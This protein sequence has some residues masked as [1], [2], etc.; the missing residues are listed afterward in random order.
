MTT[1][2]SQRYPPRIRKEGETYRIACGD[3]VLAYSGDLFA[4]GFP[5]VIRSVIGL[6]ERAQNDE[7]RQA[8]VRIAQELHS[9]LGRSLGEDIPYLADVTI[10]TI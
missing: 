8:L 9:E 5:D 1:N 6:A 2:A 10:D 3:T 4:L 7:L